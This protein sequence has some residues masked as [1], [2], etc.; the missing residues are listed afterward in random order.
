M[1]DFNLAAIKTF[2]DEEK[3]VTF[4][5]AVDQFELIHLDLDLAWLEVIQGRSLVSASKGFI[6][7]MSALEDLPE[8]IA[9]LWSSESDR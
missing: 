7:T 4:G 9:L 3:M 6:R 5:R 2:A 1:H 8:A